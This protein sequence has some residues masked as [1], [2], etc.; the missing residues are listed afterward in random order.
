MAQKAR[1]G[2]VN[3]NGKARDI[4]TG[5]KIHGLTDDAVVQDALKMMQRFDTGDV[6]VERRGEASGDIV[7]GIRVDLHVLVDLQAGGHEAFLAELKAL[8][9]TLAELQKQ[10]AAAAQ[11]EAAAKSLDDAIGEAQK[12]EPLGKLVVERLH[13]TLEFV[14]DAWKVLEAADKVGPLIAKAL[15]TAAALYQAARTLFG[16]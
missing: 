11:A 5:L 16:V 1:T 10:P 9:E 6:T 12:K 2:K 15:L 4:V 14:T 7:T 8:R 3:V 13:D